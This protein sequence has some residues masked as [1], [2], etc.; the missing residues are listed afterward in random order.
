ML[1]WDEV[2]RDTEGVDSP[3]DSQELQLLR[4]AFKMSISK[5]RLPGTQTSSRETVRRRA[6]NWQ[7]LDLKKRGCQW[8]AE[9][10]VVFYT[11]YFDITIMI[12]DKL[13]RMQMAAA[14]IRRIRSGFTSFS[15]DDKLTITEGPEHYD[16]PENWVKVVDDVLEATE[17]RIEDL[18]GYIPTDYHDGY[19]Q[20]SDEPE[21]SYSDDDS[22][23]DYY[24]R[25]S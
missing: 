9:Q 23:D 15:I 4:S 3:E 12:R 24:Y 20:S 19:L 7:F 10:A 11:L 5:G 25:S 14:K 22:D 17:E 8:F 16:C 13:P 1:L 6:G 21:T 18:K 2:L